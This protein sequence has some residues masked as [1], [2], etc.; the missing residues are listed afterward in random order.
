MSEAI[1]LRSFVVQA[2]EDL[3]ATVS[4]SGRLVWVQAPEAVQRDL[5]VP[6]NFALAF[7]AEQVGEFDAE[8]VAPGSYFLE[9]LLSLAT[10]RGRWNASRF[11]APDESWISAALTESGLGPESAVRSQVLGI[12]ELVI[13]LL[14]FRV[15]LVSD[16][17]RESFRIVA[18]SP[19]EGA[20]WPVV[21][22]PGDRG[23]LPWTIG[24]FRPDI[25]A[26]YRLATQAVRDQTRDEVD[27]FRSKSLGFLEEEVRRIFGYF[28]TTIEEIRE[29]DAAGSQDLIRAIMAERDRRLAEAVERFDPKA[30]ASL[31]SVRAVSVPTASVRL[32]FP[33][34]AKADLK[35][36]A[37]SRRIRGLACGICR[38]SDGPW[39]LGAEGHLRCARCVPT[40]AESA[41]PRARPRS[42]TPRRGT[43][44]G[45]PSAQ[46]PRGSTARSRAASARHRGS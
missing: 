9:R 4:E 40:E 27:R 34:G 14:A 6:A 35:L 31:C 28:D 2:L 43:K 5:D 18:V 11:E 44:A 19:G 10:A 32:E 7:A 26:A 29:A 25:E 30:T 8:L 21:S 41:P 1:S 17:K 37:W 38:G 45:R 36:D 16:E 15:T 24:D 23:W 42:D 22:D 39:S 20:A 12:E 46:S 33:R 3:G 13:I